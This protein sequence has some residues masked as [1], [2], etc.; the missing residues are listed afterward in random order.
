MQDGSKAVPMEVEL[1]HRDLA[2]RQSK[3][4]NESRIAGAC[5]DSLP[6]N[7]AMVVQ[8]GHES[9]VE[10]AATLNNAR[11]SFEWSRGLGC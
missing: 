7:V 11:W 1:I 5:V 10:L 8:L 6:V 4:A 9:R 3:T 2:S